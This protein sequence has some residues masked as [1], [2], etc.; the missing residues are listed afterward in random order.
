MSLQQQL[1]NLSPD[2]LQRLHQRGFS[3]SRLAGWAASLA[4][5][6]PERN[7]LQGR[8]EPPRPED[9]HDAPSLGSPEYERCLELGRKALREGQVALCVLAGGMATRMGGVVKALVEAIPSKTFLELRWLE[10]E[11]LRRAHG[12]PGV[13]LWLMTSEAT[14]TPIR[15]ALGDR[16]DGVD[17]A[18][19]EQHVSLRLSEQGSLF[20]DE[21]GEPSVYATGHG[22]LPDALRES[23]LLGRFVE[24]GGKYVW[25]ANL[26][27]LGAMVDEALLGWHIAHGG[28]LSVEVVDK[29]GSDKG[30]GPVRWNDGLVFAEEFRLPRDFNAAS[31]P[32]FS[33][34]TF[35]VD[36]QALLQLNMT[37]TYVYVEKKVGESKAIQFER[38]INEITAALTPH[39]LRLPRTGPGSRFL[40][41]KDMAELERR[42]PEIEEVLR[43][44]G[45]L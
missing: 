42:R 2:L 1:Q 44:R 39:C 17:C 29:V 12:E 37:W 35:L 5:H 25:I 36:A 26:D 20:L 27:N 23:G 40:P 45:L 19:F 11:Q 14:N 31:V 41:V 4:A 34:N 21:H 13:P 38:I 7:R 15:E 22:D 6:N 33:T 16:C 28:E 30:G 18:T 10:H 43:G 3:E 24:R 32:V 9:I 8:V